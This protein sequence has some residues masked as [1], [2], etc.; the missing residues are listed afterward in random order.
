MVEEVRTYIQAQRLLRDGAR[1]LV[2]LS[3]GAD[4][5]CLLHILTDLG[6][7]V[8]AAHCNFHLRGEESN[9]DERFVR[10]LCESL[11]VRLYVQSF[12]T[13]T[14]ARQHGISIEMA[15]RDLRYAWFEKLRQAVNAEA[16]AVAHHRNDQAET[17]LMN[18]LR[19][20]GVRGLGG[21]RPKN[22]H[23]IRPLLCVSRHEI[24][25]YMT[26]HDYPY[27]T[28]ST[29][30][31][32]RIRRNALRAE[33]ADRTD[34]EI[35]HLCHTAELLQHYDALLQALLQGT[36]I[37]AEC[38]SVLL[39]ELLAPYGLNATQVENIRTAL[40]GSNKRFETEEFT[41]VINHGQL[42]IESNQTNKTDHTKKSD[43]QLSEQFDADMLPERMVLRHW[44]PGDAFYPLSNKGRAGRKK[45]QDFF[46]DLKLSVEEKNQVWLLCDADKP[47]EIIWVVGYRISDKYK[48]SSSTKESR[49]L[50]IENGALK[51]CTLE[52]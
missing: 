4:S 16:I 39:Y 7:E 19:G 11:G 52:S 23:V 20:T 15:A 17:L 21:M 2:G 13:T 33:L 50:T 29:N 31:D 30:A 9:G 10:N 45:L 8:V 35:H 24:E 46:S 44:Q 3:G 42:T 47:K 32:T 48:I 26:V 12:D 1:V 34:A 37:P 5:V 28:D 18:L 6:Y 49:R 22:G 14:Y 40:P 41:A 51:C 25:A 27:V 36:P 43:L 38:Q